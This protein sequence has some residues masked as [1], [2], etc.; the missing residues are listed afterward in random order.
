LGNAV[1]FND[2]ELVDGGSMLTSESDEREDSCGEGLDGAVNGK[3][4]R[5]C[6]GCFGE[7]RGKEDAIAR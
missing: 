2:D 1:G 5:R 7:L 4:E 3:G 6:A